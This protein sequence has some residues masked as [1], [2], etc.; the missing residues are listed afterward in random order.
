[1]AHTTDVTALVRYEARDISFDENTNIFEY[2]LELVNVSDLPLSGPFLFRIKDIKST[3]GPVTV[4]GLFNSGIIFTAKR[5][6]TLLP[7]E[8]TIATRVRIQASLAVREKLASPSKRNPGIGL[9]GRVY[10][11]S[12]DKPN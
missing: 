3:I 4:Q 9:I 2:D 1:M 5:S 12:N 11:T 6:E 7:G 8:H 10:A